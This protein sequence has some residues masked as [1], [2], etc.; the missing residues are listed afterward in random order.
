MHCTWIIIY[1]YYIT[2]AATSGQIAEGLSLHTIKV[3]NRLNYE[4]K[5][6]LFHTANQHQND[7]NDNNI[8]LHTIHLISN[9]IHIITVI[10]F[11]FTLNSL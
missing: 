3:N 11:L 2:G 7:K 8:T 10:L 9:L 1:I 6:I 4:E 5:K